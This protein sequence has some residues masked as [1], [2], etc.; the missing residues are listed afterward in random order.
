[1]ALPKGTKEKL[2]NLRA[3]F[4]EMGRAAV[5]F[6]GGLDSGFLLKFGHDVIGEQII[7]VIGV[8]PSVPRRELEA[9]TSFAERHRIPYRLIETHEMDDPNYRANPVDRC[10]H[11][12]TELFGKLK[13][14]AEK[15]KYPF[16]MDGTNESDSGDHRPGRAAAKAKG[17]RSPLAEVG[18]S[19][20][21]I[22]LAAREMG[23]DIW[24]KASFACLGSRFP[25]GTAITVEGLSRVERCED[26]LRNLGLRQ[27]RVRHHGSIARIEVEESDFPTVLLYREEIVKVFRENGYRYVAL[28]LQGYRTGSMN[29]AIA[30]PGKEGGKAA[31]K[32]KQKQRQPKWM[33]AWKPRTYGS[34]WTTVY[35]DGASKGNPGPASIAVLLY[36][37]EGRE[38][39]RESCSIG[40]ATNN[41]AEYRA[42]EAGLEAALDRGVTHA[43]VLSDSELV[44]KQIR[45]EYKIKNTNLM[46][47]VGRVQAL[48]RRFQGFRIEAVS[49]EDNRMADWLAARE[50]ARRAE[51]GSG[52]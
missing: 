19:K 29:E 30:G 9:A 2:E 3:L 47:H 23:L 25:Y 12:K 16:I 50:T 1:M 15:E 26:L 37:H 46:R 31:G 34:G 14:F 5:A 45:G 41:V 52:S 22:R 32:G 40:E 27:F 6:S 28:D 24:D 11:C 7:G 48:R 36:D 51:K 42:V 44:V 49:R 13:E 17:V 38:I 39:F 43:A 18:L 10:Y 4:S 20:D 21:D 33:A 35:V 8:S